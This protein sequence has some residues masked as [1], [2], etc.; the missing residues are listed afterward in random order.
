MRKRKQYGGQNSEVSEESI[1]VLESRAAELQTLLEQSRQAAERASKEYENAETALR[2]AEAEKAKVN[3][4]AA[5]KIQANITATK[6]Q[7]NLQSKRN[8]LTQ[9][10]TTAN[11]EYNTAVKTQES[12]Q[13]TLETAQ[14]T[15]TD[16]IA[17]EKK[18][19]E[20]K[21]AKAIEQA[22][23]N[24]LAKSLAAELAA[25]ETKKKEKEQALLSIEKREAAAYDP[26]H[27]SGL[28]AWFDA[29]KLSG[30][31]QT[32]LTTWNSTTSIFPISPTPPSFT[33]QATIAMKDDMKIVRLSTVQ[34]LNLN[35]TVQLP[36]FTLFIV[37]RHSGTNRN[38]IFQGSTA[39]GTVFGFTTNKQSYFAI[40][41]SNNLSTAPVADTN[42]DILS[43]SRNAAKAASFSNNGQKI[44]EYTNTTQ[45]FDGLSVNT[46]TQKSDAEIAEVVLYNRA[47]STDEIQ[48][49]EGL[50]ARK[51]NL[52]DSLNTSHPYKTIF[53]DLLGVLSGGRKKRRM[54]KL[55]RKTKKVRK[56]RRRTTYRR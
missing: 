47:L 42:W 36:E 24:S 52:R 25:L 2:T 28:R 8:N 39:S 18:S 20:D 38:A 37:C 48:K 9:K 43:F 10:K 53:P 31:N 34:S 26:S 17:A 7:S 23:A 3:A 14:K 56:A 22:Q 15:L 45:G 35:S 6:L 12:V 55:K 44:I 5:I 41:T 16:A 21:N 33:G 49:I 32:A 13:K 46:G 19:Q 54:R 27:L 1:E 29:S 11:T 50:L 4:N 30:D 51:W 40:G